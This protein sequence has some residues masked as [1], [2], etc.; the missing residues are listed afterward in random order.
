[1]VSEG[2]VELDN[3]YPN[4]GTVKMCILYGN[5][6]KPFVCISINNEN[7]YHDNVSDMSYYVTLESFK[8]FIVKNFRAKLKLKE[9]D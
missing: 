5:E 3:V 8:K 4:R 9:D 1:M 7:E 2:E 6:G